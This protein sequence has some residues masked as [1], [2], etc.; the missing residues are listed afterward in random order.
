MNDD[1][2]WV[3]NMLRS[4][5]CQ[6]CKRYFV[7]HCVLVKESMQSPDRYRNKKQGKKRQVEVGAIYQSLWPMPYLDFSWLLWH[8]CRRTPL[9]ITRWFYF[10]ALCKAIIWPHLTCALRCNDWLG[11]LRLAPR[12]KI[13]GQTA[14][15]MCLPVVKSVPVGVE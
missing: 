14:L 15:K 5:I 11:I 4:L 12:R 13:K 6:R 2:S 7:F 1:I 3:T 10:A 8:E 9:L